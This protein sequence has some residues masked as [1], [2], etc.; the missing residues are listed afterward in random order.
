MLLRRVLTRLL[1]LDAGLLLTS[2]YPADGLL[3]DPLFHHMMVPVIEMI[4][5]ALTEWRIPDGVDYRPLNAG[6]GRGA[7]F[8]SGSWTVTGSPGPANSWPPSASCA[9]PGMPTGSSAG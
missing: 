4:Q 8:A 6:D 9:A 7:G 2:N 5:S 3:P 1:S